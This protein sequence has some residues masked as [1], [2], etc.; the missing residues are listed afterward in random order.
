MGATA[1]D[2]GVGPAQTVAATSKLGLA[3]FMAVAVPVYAVQIAAR[4]PCC[5][6]TLLPTRS[7]CSFFALALGMLYYRTHRIRAALI[8][9]HVAFNAHEPVAAV[10]LVRRASP[11]GAANAV[12]LPP[13]PFPLL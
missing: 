12:P 11:G 9:L 6:K 7:R 5:R 10:A 3:A 2:F 13:S 8:V 1:A 4:W